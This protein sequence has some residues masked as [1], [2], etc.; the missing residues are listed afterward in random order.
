MTKDALQVIQIGASTSDLAGTLRLFTDAFGFQNAGGQGLWGKTI[1]VQG[2]A[3]DS[4]AIMW[5]MVG[6]QEF[7]QLEFFH[8]SK[9]APRPKRAD[10]TPADHGWGRFGLAVSDFDRAM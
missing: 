1:G 4:R 3:P 8:Y 7:F 10:W 5:W 2:L 9:P 6:A